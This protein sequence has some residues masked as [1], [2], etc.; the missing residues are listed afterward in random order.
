M[1]NDNFLNCSDRHFT[2]AAAI[3]PN[4]TTEIEVTRAIYVGVA[5]DITAILRDDSAAVL[6]K[7]MPVGVWFIR[8]KIIKSTGTAATNLV[9]LY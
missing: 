2:R 4:D 8:A 6:F 1:S 9:A 5:G 7:A 3:A